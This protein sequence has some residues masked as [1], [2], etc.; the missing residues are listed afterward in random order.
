MKPG[1]VF[2]FHSSSDDMGLLWV[3]L[4]RWKFGV[5]VEVYTTLTWICLLVW[6]SKSCHMVWSVLNWHSGYANWCMI[7]MCIYQGKKKLFDWYYN[8][9][10]HL[11][12]V[13]K[14]INTLSWTWSK[15]FSTGSTSFI[16]LCLSSNE[17]CMFIL[18]DQLFKH[19][20]T[21]SE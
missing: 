12:L 18:F 13:I 20:E 19:S 17:L 16:I 6:L 4:Q 15:M 11:I 8:I 10:R 21:N 9:R 5:W 1:A 7:D 3:S 2:L 14:I